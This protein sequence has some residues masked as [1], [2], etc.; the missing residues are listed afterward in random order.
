MGLRSTLIVL[1]AL[2][3]AAGAML[4]AA[5]QRAGIP[6]LWIGGIALLG[7]VFERWRYR[8]GQLG[9]DGTEGYDNGHGALGEPWERTSERFQD[10]ETGS[11]VEVLFNPRTGERRYR[12]VD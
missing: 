6:V 7:L 3:A 12:K 4:L 11:T 5:G 9:H 1:A 10:P 2:V 8:E